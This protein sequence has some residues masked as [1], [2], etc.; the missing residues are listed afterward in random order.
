[1][2]GGLGMPG[3]GLPPGD[4]LGARGSL[5]DQTAAA[6][7]TAQRARVLDAESAPAGA[8][9][10]EKRLDAARE[11]AG[12]LV[13]TAFVKP[14]LSEMRASSMAAAPFKPGTWEKRFG[15]VI[16]GMVA[17]ELVGSSGWGLVDRLAERFVGLA[18]LEEH[19]EARIA[20]KHAEGER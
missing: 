3:G 14:V 2:M 5:L 8:V 12:E 7:R 20:I 6:S 9:S 4:M 18:R 10:F 11:A 1:M 15:P 13:A 19:G 16:D 17:Q